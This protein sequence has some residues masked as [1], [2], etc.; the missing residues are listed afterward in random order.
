MASPLFLLVNKAD[1]LRMMEIHSEFDLF[2][3]IKWFNVEH[4]YTNRE[5][6]WLKGAV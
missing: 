4:T 3:Q 5:K 1:S 6:A 2:K